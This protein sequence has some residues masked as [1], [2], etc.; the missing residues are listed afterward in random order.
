MR[1]VVINVPEAPGLE[2]LQKILRSIKEAINPDPWGEQIPIFLVGSAKALLLMRML[3]LH[4]LS[5]IF[6]EVR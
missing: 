3:R 6:F 2:G 1:T 5:A 4:R